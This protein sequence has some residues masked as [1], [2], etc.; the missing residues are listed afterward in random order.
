MVSELTLVFQS[1]KQ[2]EFFDHFVVPIVSRVE[3]RSRHV[4]KGAIRRCGI[5]HRWGLNLAPGISRNGADERA[6]QESG[7]RGA[8]IGGPEGERDER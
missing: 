1:P 8:R 5:P 7:A 4:R 6:V 2:I 3:A